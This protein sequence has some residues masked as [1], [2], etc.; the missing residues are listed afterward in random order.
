MYLQDLE[1]IDTVIEHIATVI[2]RIDTVIER[3]GSIILLLRSMR[4]HYC[5]NTFS[6]M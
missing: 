5:L 6:R 2:E 3:I 4:H 1:R